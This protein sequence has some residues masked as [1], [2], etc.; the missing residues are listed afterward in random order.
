MHPSHLANAAILLESGWTFSSGAGAD[1]RQ[2]AALLEFL[3]LRGPTGEIELPPEERRR[4]AHLLRM[5]ARLD[6][7]FPMRVPT[8]PGAAFFG[9]RRVHGA[10]GDLAGSGKTKQ[11][12][13]AGFGAS[14]FQ[15]FCACIGEA[16]EHD[17][18]FL[19]RHDHRLSSEGTLPLLDGGLSAAGVINAALILREAGDN[20]WPAPRTS[21]GYAAGPTLAAAAQ[22]AILECIERHAISLWFNGLQKPALMTASDAAVQQIRLLRGDAAPCCRLL[23]LHH[24]IQGAPAV[25]AYSVSSDG[26]IAVGF[27]C[28]LSADDALLKA[29]KELCQGEFA[30]HMECQAGSA[31]VASFSARSK[32][33][34]QKT[35][36]F[37]SVF[38]ESGGDPSYPDLP[39]LSAALGGIVQFVNLTVS[40]DA[41]PV[42]CA[43]VDGLRDIAGE[44]GPEQTGPL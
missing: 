34:A 44:T 18:M 42:V 7:V 11:T 12:D 36:L 26:K 28:A 17:A 13:Y 8:A 14:L 19:R 32:M 1:K 23:R 27:G 5:A 2:P 41:V 3:G 20:P 30:L 33:F 37:E 15:A 43:L 39:T 6:A 29:V 31:G 40:E 35:A 16:A 9:A 10:D 4:F 22:S 38:D 25:A 21:T 24:D